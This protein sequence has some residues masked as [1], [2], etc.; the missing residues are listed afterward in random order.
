M[1]FFFF[2]SLN[3]FYLI[4]IALLTFVSFFFFPKKNQ[5]KLNFTLSYCET[6]ADDPYNP[7]IKTKGINFLKLNAK[8]VIDSCK[9]DIKKYPKNEILKYNLLRGYKK[10]AFDKKKPRIH[11]KEIVSLI[12]TLTASNNDY[13]KFQYATLL[14]SSFYIEPNINKSFSILNELRNK[15]KDFDNLNYQLGMVYQALYIGENDFDLDSFNFFVNCIKTKESFKNRCKTEL[16]NYYKWG[17]KNIEYDG[18]KAVYNLTESQDDYM[19]KIWLASHYFFNK[20]YGS[21]KTGKKLL[22]ESVNYLTQEKNIK[23]SEYDP[24]EIP[25]ELSWSLSLLSSQYL[26]EKDF[27]KAKKYGE[28]ALNILEESDVVNSGVHQGENFEYEY[29]YINDLLFP[30]LYFIYDR[31]ESGFQDKKKADYIFKKIKKKSDEEGFLYIRSLYADK[32]L[33][34]NYEKSFEL[35]KKYEAAF[36]DDEYI[37]PRVLHSL[38]S[39]YFYGQGVKASKE[40]ALDIFLQSAQSYNDTFSMNSLGMMYFS[41]E[42][43]PVDLQ[44]SY[45]WINKAVENNPY[46]DFALVEL[47]KFYLEGIVVKK[48]VQKGIQLLDNASLVGN[49]DASKQLADIYENGFIVQ[50][51]LQKAQEYLE[52]ITLSGEAYSTASQIYNS[53][54]LAQ[55]KLN[56]ILEEKQQI[57]IANK[58]KKYA[59]LI[60]NNNYKFF[61]KLKSPIN[62]IN[63][64][65]KT[66]FN[67][68]GYDVIYIK[69]GTNKKINQELNKL[70]DKVSYDDS[71]LIY[72]AGHGKFDEE[73]DVGYWIPVDGE[74]DIDTDWI[75]N[76]KITKKLKAFKSRKIAVIADSCYSGTLF[77]GVTINEKDFNKKNI[78]TRVAMTSGGLEP[79]LDSIGDENSLFANLINESLNKGKNKIFLSK[80]FSEIQLEFNK[81]IKKGVLDQ[82]PQYAPLIKSGHKGGDYIFEKK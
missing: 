55:D 77:R 82:V 56:K 39:H 75:T 49:H 11:S 7:D 34:I 18:T 68:F 19:A 21:I 65:G 3:Y 70:K 44:K 15:N 46:N 53:K 8:K 47:S 29:V 48:S 5:T 50:R 60:G 6:I 2:K 41:G 76:Y 20:E 62:D 37:H 25:R 73:I 9:K 33:G 13:Y 80:I 35:V 59:L 32:K 57:K 69:N 72:Y 24:Y 52:R 71:V 51:N 78:N 36:R 67:K 12:K 42:G 10:N 38:G 74:I 45:K 40:K 1:N 26:K 14:N 79:V 31:E 81:L 54:V 27:K 58:S 66:L 30:S 16:A 61:P 28:K 63:K 23:Y 4:T 22:K 43:V 17:S 64:I